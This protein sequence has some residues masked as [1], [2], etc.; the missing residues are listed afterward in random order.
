MAAAA[1]DPVLLDELRQAFAESLFN[2]IGLMERSRCD[3]NWNVAVMRIKGLAA[4]FYA[5]ELMDLSDEAL[6]SAPGDPA[7]LRKLKAY[8]KRF[9]EG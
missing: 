8:H 1:N 5:E 6:D 2:Q 9:N 4:G 3:G 7:I